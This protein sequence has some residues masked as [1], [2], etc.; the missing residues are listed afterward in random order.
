MQAHAPAEACPWTVFDRN[1]IDKVL[2]DHGLPAYLAK[3]LPEDRVSELSDLIADVFGV[4]PSSKTVV[5][6]T[7]ETVRKLAQAGNVILIGRGATVVT[8]RMP[9]VLHVRI[10]APLEQRIE[11]CIEAYQ[12]K[13]AEARKFCPTEDRA[14]RRYLKKYFGVDAND[15]LQYHLIINTGQVSYAEAARIIGDAVLNLP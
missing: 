1:L 2:E 14:R 10:V 13:R 12:M 7:V 5:Q 9:R 15:P 3:F 11:H 8:A 4:H 6:K